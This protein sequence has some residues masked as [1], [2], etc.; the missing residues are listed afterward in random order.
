MANKAPQTK[1]AELKLKR[2]GRRF[3]ATW[4]VKSSATSDEETRATHRQ[5][6]WQ[7]FDRK[8]SK[9]VQVGSS[10]ATVGDKSDTCEL[11]ETAWSYT[12][13]KAVRVMVYYVHQY[14]KSSGEIVKLESSEI[15]HKQMTFE[16]PGK[17]AIGKR[18]IEDGIVKC[19]LSVTDVRGT[20]YARYGSKMTMTRTSFIN[21]VKKTIKRQLANE[22]HLSA[23][24]KYSY[25][26]SYPDSQAQSLTREKDY[27]KYEFS[28][29]TTG[30]G[31]KAVSVS[32]ELM[33]KIAQ[34][35]VITGI[36]VY[37]SIVRVALKNSSTGQT[38]ARM[39]L[40]VGYSLSNS[41]S[42]WED[43]GSE[44]HGAANYMECN[45]GLINPELGYRVFFRIAVRRGDEAFD[46]YSDPLE[47]K[48]LYNVPQRGQADPSVLSI[49]ESETVTDTDS[50][51]LTVAWDTNTNYNGTE[52]AWS[53]D[54][55]AWESTKAPTSM[56]MRDIEWAK[57]WTQTSD[58]D[59]AATI[60]VAELD[61]NTTYYFRARRYNTD[62][63]SLITGWSQIASATTGALASGVL[64]NAPEYAAQGEPLTV[65]WV[66]GGD[67]PQ[68]DWAVSTS[69]VDE[70]GNV[71]TWNSEP[72]AD[73]TSVFTVP[74]DYVGYGGTVDVT[75]TASNGN[76]K[77]NERTETVALYARPSVTITAPSTITALPYSFAVDASESCSASVSL[78]SMGV[79]AST[80]TD[81]N[82]QFEGDVVWQDTVQLDG[83]TPNALQV[84]LSAGLINGCTYHL[85]VEPFTDFLAGDSVQSEDLLTAWA[86]EAKAPSSD[87]VIAI[88]AEAGSASI[89]IAADDSAL[90]TDTYSV[91]RH[92]VNGLYLIASDLQDGDTVVDA[93]APY[94]AVES[95]EYVLAATTQDGDMDWDGF[96]FEHKR[97]DLLITFGGQSISLPYNIVV[98]DAYAKDFE[99]I[100]YL[101]GTT[102]GYWNDGAAHTA[103]MET[104]LTKFGSYEQQQ[105]VAEL[106]RHAGTCFVRTP[107]GHAYEADVQLGSITW[108]HASGI[109]SCSFTATEVNNGEYLATR[110][111]PTAA[112]DAEE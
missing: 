22:S 96:P 77:Q 84:P 32:R 94:H 28:A 9:W 92:A 88:D 35:P 111:E 58:W 53:T 45:R 1:P 97:K 87:S 108:S 85:R 14:A 69:Y 105:A 27:I 19:E 91:Y 59:K 15:A 11:S 4:T 56:S 49:V 5:V 103:T 99:S 34:K 79:T 16:K 60:K 30:P 72:G 106:A 95:M 18:S 17:M 44:I 29:Y 104:A 12:H 102:A 78:V 40:Q 74:G 90:A 107:A 112:Q 83:D 47:C 39:Q 64:V 67:R 109:V 10:Y 55:E 86:H 31:G 73:E 89:T 8:K 101:D 75:V 70:D 25:T 82:E 63:E 71:Q 38:G 98:A 43:I 26:F 110:L 93:V 100:K 52:L 13:C 57:N 65:S 20:K 23:E 51:K 6:I 2:S 37:D 7:R 80:P 54:M 36:S 61:E 62:N 50:I 3:T 81:D 68:T 76:G 33:H 24:G 41:V 42:S 21:G 48:K 66:L 46:N